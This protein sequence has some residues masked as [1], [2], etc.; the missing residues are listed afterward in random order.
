M[1]CQVLDLSGLLKTLSAIFWAITLTVFNLFQSNN[2]LRSPLDIIV[3]AAG[4]LC[5]FILFT[6]YGAVQMSRSHVAP[7][8]SAFSVSKRNH[9]F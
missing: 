7:N 5:S 2:K 3:T 9:T 4:F 1:S 6:T 8:L